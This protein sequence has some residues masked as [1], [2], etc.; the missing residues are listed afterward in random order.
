[1]TYTDKRVQTINEIVNGCQIIKMYNWGK[2]MEER[3]RETRRHE[4]LHIY[5]SSY[6]RALN[7]GLGFAGLTLI[8]LA[9]FG[10]IWFMDRYLQPENVFST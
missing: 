8:S 6:L 2:A 10:G 4:L 7:I 9:T 3:V 1:M 5:K